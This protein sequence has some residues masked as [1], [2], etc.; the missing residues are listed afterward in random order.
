MLKSLS[1]VFIGAVLFAAS[2][3][4]SSDKGSINRSAVKNIT[5]S[6]ILENAK[7]KAFFKNN[8]SYLKANQEE[9]NLVDKHVIFAVDA[10]DSIDYAENPKLVKGVAQAVL[11]QTMNYNNCYAMTVI[12]FSD[13]VDISPTYVFCS[14]VGAQAF[15]ADTLLDKGLP[16]NRA[17]GVSTDITSA[18]MAAGYV[19]DGEGKD[20]NFVSNNKDFITIGDGPDNVKNMDKQPQYS[21]TTLDL[22]KRYGA[23]SHAVAIMPS[24]NEY[25]GDLI[26]RNT[27]DYYQKN[28]I[29]PQNSNIKYFNQ[30]VHGKFPLSVRAGFYTEAENF[31][32]V[33]GA[34]RQ[35]LRHVIN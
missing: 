13:R 7:R 22:A 31:T 4:S 27:V 34:V 23:T 1:G 21:Y 30:A 14:M 19:W 9:I 26:K 11:D 6:S 29:T 18:I 3:A 12:R 8:V 10:S 20:L 16:F 15:V 33:S 24:K 35:V 2:P 5:T 32:G 28:L 25:N 17:L